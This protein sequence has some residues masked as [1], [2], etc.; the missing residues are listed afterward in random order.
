M[1]A[2]PNTGLSVTDRVFSDDNPEDIDESTPESALHRNVDLA[3]IKA[4]EE[5]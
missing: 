1:F 4:D 2:A 5:G 3:V